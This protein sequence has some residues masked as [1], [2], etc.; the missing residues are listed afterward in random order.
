M[1]AHARGDAG[2]PSGGINTC[3]RFPWEKERWE[4][5]TL[6]KH[7]RLHRHQLKAASH[8]DR[9]FSR[10]LGQTPR[11]T[12]HQ[13]KSVQI[14]QC[15]FEIILFQGRSVWV[16]SALLVLNWFPE[17]QQRN[18]EDQDKDR[19]QAK[20]SIWQVTFCSW[21]FVSGFRPFMVTETLPLAFCTFRS[22]YLQDVSQV[23]RS[24]PHEQ[25]CC[26]VSSKH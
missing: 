17:R 25:I 7:Q 3:E 15:K 11:T 8:Y 2:S 9:T 10:S 22:H 16:V 24:K 1:L 21:P 6:L 4:P 19:R 5:R 20:Q 13:D 14:S 18:C 12:F 23:E 26:T